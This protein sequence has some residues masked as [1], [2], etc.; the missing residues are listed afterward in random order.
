MTARVSD[1]IE[2]W[3]NLNLR[4]FQNF[5]LGTGTGAKDNSFTEPFVKSKFTEGQAGLV[6]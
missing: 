5:H 6:L 3:Y 1:C 2:Y 4:A